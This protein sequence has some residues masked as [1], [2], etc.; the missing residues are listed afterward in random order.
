MFRAA[1]ILFYLFLATFAF[2]AD[3]DSIIT[4]A[5][6]ND[7]EIKLLKL[8]YEKAVLD[9]V[10]TGRLDPV[11]FSIT[12][13]RNGIGV[14][15]NWTRPEDTFG[16]FLAPEVTFYSGEE[17]GTAIT[18]SV[19]YSAAGSTENGPD[20]DIAVSQSLNRMLGLYHKKK[21]NELL[22]FHTVERARLS[23]ASRSVD[24]QIDVYVQLS[25]LYQVRREMLDAYA[26]F[27]QS[28][29][30]YKEMTTY[31]Y[32][33]KGTPSWDLV[34]TEYLRLK[35]KQETLKVK[36]ERQRELFFLRFGVRLEAVPEEI[37]SLPAEY[38]SGARDRELAGEYL[39]KL[40]EEAY[41]EKVFQLRTKYPEFDLLFN[42]QNYEDSR[43]GINSNISTGLSWS[44]GGL[45]LSVLSG[46]RLEQELFFVSFILTY[47]LPDFQK[48]EYDL[49]VA[50]KEYEMSALET[51]LARREGQIQFGEYELTYLDA[52]DSLENLD[53]TIELKE[54]EIKKAE[55]D[56]RSGLLSRSAFLRLETQRDSLLMQKNSLEIS[57]IVAALRTQKLAYPEPK[58]E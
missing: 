37:R 10:F 27:I 22:S 44:L 30:K 11:E 15:W 54:I 39:G 35:N 45:S 25:L 55:A 7:T 5:L 57:C 16:F 48:E 23:L 46:L 42:F 29:S 50:Q 17:I 26:E 20:V 51:K 34:E 31:N 40:K 49:S 21:W 28:E 58:Q 12:T 3:A 32:Y 2:C 33:R 47:T 14:Q 56:V 1:I 13:G 6:E 38:V 8:Q 24:V 53:Y 52:L 9:D 4:A 36:W 41:K 43:Q 19:G 18:V